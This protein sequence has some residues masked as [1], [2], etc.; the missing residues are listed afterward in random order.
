MP[1]KRDFN[2][3][4][5]KRFNTRAKYHL[6]SDLGF[7]LTNPNDSFDLARSLLSEYAD[8]FDTTKDED[9]NITFTSDADK[10]RMAIA[11]ES[12]GY[13]ASSPEQTT[14]FLEARLHELIAQGYVPK[15]EKHLHEFTLNVAG[16]AAK[17]LKKQFP[18]QV[19]EKRDQ[20]A[21]KPTKSHKAEYVAATE[22]DYTNIQDV[23]RYLYEIGNISPSHAS[24]LLVALG[25]LRPETGI[26]NGLRN[27][28]RRVK[29]NLQAR[30]EMYQAKK[31]SDFE[32]SG[33]RIIEAFLARSM[34]NP[35]LQ[36]SLR[37]ADAMMAV[38]YVMVKIHQ[39]GDVRANVP[40]ERANKYDGMGTSIPIEQ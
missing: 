2:Y 9:G 3:N 20:P 35:D 10:E 1:D 38:G 33:L 8:Q 6:K 13:D 40:R 34:Q 12:L 39:Q 7:D 32:Q 23:I 25:Y 31:P 17:S 36:L 30:I 26:T 21:S 24:A 11:V 14:Q 18:V 5:V 28:V 15:K 16:F 29:T 22:P 19:K 37:E 27:D 4:R